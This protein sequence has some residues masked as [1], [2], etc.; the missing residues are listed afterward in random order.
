[1]T[2]FEK[3]FSS[4]GFTTVLAIIVLVFT[5]WFS[6]KTVEG[7]YLVTKDKVPYI[8]VNINWSEDRRLELD[9]DISYDAAVELTKKLNESITKNKK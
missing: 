5:Y 2:L 4:L 3:L 1:M 7:Y 8:I 6:S 9:R